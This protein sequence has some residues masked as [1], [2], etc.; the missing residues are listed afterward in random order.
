MA[1]TNSG[2]Y[3]LAMLV[4]L[5]VIVMALVRRRPSLPEE[6][7]A[8][9]FV[10]GPTL[11]WIVDDEHV[12]AGYIKVAQE[13]VERTQ[14]KD[15]KIIPLLGRDAVLAKLARPVPNAKQL[16]PHLWRAYAIAALLEE[17]GG[18]VMDGTSTVCVGPSIYPHVAKVQAAMFGTDPNEAI[19]STV[20]PGPA[21]YAGWS[22]TAHHTAWAYAVDMY[23]A[24]IERGSTAWTAVE[25]RHIELKIWDEQKKRGA[26]VVRSVDGGRLPNGKLRQLEDIF[27][28]TFNGTTDPLLALTPETVYVSYDGNMLKRRHEFN[29]FLRLSPDQV[30]NSDIYWTKYAGF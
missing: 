17:Q 14:G 28:R 22:A 8:S 21:P 25:A 3:A 24:I 6:A 11:W 15:F 13:T 9:L 20:A 26:V 12:G 4:L 30:R 2:E 27:G 18:L 7:F 29:W 16:P 10:L 1:S 19:A 5:I 23:R